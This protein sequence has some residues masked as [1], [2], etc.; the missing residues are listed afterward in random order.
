MG[1]AAEPETLAPLQA[2][3]LNKAINAA[4]GNKRFVDRWNGL[5]ADAGGG[6]PEELARLT[7]SEVDRWAAVAK[8]ANIRLQ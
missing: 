4:F 3:R 1:A 5:G 7:G 6:T 8:R 2:L